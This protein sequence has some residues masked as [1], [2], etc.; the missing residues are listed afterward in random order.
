MTFCA[1]GCG[2]EAG[3][4]SA[5]GYENLP[6]KF[7]HGHNTRLK[8]PSSG[9]RKIM[10]SMDVFPDDDC[11]YWMG[12]NGGRSK[13]GCV[14]HY[15]KH[16]KVHRVIYEHCIGQIPQGM[17]IHHSCGK[18]NCI[19][20]SHLKLCHHG[21]HSKQHKLEYWNEEVSSRIRN[22]GGDPKNHKIC[23]GC[24]L[25]KERTEFTKANNRKD[26]LNGYCKECCKNRWIRWKEENL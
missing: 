16:E 19:N 3:L 6:R 2:I 10:G 25:L 8:K 14:R 9:L 13:H 15:G 12:A 18:E 11:L 5:A 24:R 1:C 4:Y 20:P 26:E 23:S 17:I 21:E 22:A 7:I